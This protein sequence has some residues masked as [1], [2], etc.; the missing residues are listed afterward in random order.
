LEQDG[1]DQYS[2]TP[3]LVRKNRR[4]DLWVTLAPALYYRLRFI[5]TN[6]DE[7]YRVNSMDLT[8]SYQGNL[9]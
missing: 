4:S 8:V 7:F 3:E 6:P 2:F 9:S 1:E 5:A